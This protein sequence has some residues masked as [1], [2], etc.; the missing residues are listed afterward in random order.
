MFQVDFATLLKTSRGL[1]WRLQRRLKLPKTSLRCWS[2]TET[3]RSSKFPVSA[4]T[5]TM[6]SLSRRSWKTSL[7]T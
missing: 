7:T 3:S 1:L 4:A 2:S 6:T 5:S